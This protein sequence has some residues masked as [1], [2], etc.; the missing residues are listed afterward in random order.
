MEPLLID[1]FLPSLTGCV[2][3]AVMYILVILCLC[4]LTPWMAEAMR[5]DYL[6]QLRQ[7]T[8]DMFYHGFNNYMEHAFPEDEVCSIGSRC[9]HAV[10]IYTNI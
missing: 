7:E 9:T 4:I 3:N 1:Y 5:D 2:P 10:Q 6:R 8:V